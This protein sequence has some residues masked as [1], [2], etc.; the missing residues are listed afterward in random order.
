[1]KGQIEEY[2]KDIREEL[3]AKAN[4]EV[5][6]TAEWYKVRYIKDKITALQA[7]IKEIEV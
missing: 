2:E 1:L 7:Q 3:E 4:G 5:E 6:E